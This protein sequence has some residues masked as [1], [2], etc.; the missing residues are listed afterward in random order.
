MDAAS[1][2]SAAARLATLA[3]LSSRSGGMAEV[4][5][6]TAAAGPSAMA[7]MAEQTLTEFCSQQPAMSQVDH[8][9]IHEVLMKLS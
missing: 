6:D 4:A 1:P 9:L 7:S 8:G 3:A 2:G 5:H